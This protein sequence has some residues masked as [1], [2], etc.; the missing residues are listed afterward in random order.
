MITNLFLDGKL[1]RVLVSHIGG[2][3]ISNLL[4]ILGFEN[5]GFN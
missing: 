2:T 1:D 4:L 3:L 5:F